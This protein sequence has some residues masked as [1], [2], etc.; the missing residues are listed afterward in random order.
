MPIEDVLPR[1]AN[2]TTLTAWVCYNPIS[3]GIESFAFTNFNESRKICDV[4]FFSI[5]LHFPQ[6]DV[7]VSASGC[8]PAFAVGLEVGRVY[9]QVVIVPGYE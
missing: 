1:G 8:K 7:V 5:S 4:S 6:P 9:W 2:R 3:D